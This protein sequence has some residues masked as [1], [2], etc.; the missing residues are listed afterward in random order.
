LGWVGIPLFYKSLSE[1]NATTGELLLDEVESAE[2]IDQQAEQLEAK[3]SE[4]EEA[5]RRAEA[6]EA[7]AA[8]LRAEIEKLRR[9]GGL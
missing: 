5:R 1:F 2:K 6:A 3:A 4:L 7:E 8:R 9:S